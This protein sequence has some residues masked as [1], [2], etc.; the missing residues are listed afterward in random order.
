MG[1]KQFL[2][3]R[4]RIAFSLVGLL[5]TCVSILPGW[6]IDHLCQPIAQTIGPNI[7]ST[8]VSKSNDS[9]LWFAGFNMVNDTQQMGNKQFLMFRV[10]RNVH[11][12]QH[13]VWYRPWKFVTRYCNFIQDTWS[14]GGTIISVI[15]YALMESFTYTRT[16]PSRLDWSG[17]LS[18]L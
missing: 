8:K 10:R 17:K 13:N 18:W 9:S 14:S 6:L 3:F 12:T 11:C 7:S 1:N 4:A 2:M 15:T 5:T 16:P